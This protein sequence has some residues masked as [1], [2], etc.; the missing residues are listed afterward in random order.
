MPAI[1]DLREGDLYSNSMFSNTEA[2]I[3]TVVF[4]ALQVAHLSHSAADKMAP[5]PK[6]DEDEET[7]MVSSSEPRM[8][9][10]IGWLGLNFLTYCTA[11]QLWHGNVHLSSSTQYFHGYDE[12]SIAGKALEQ[13]TGVTHCEPNQCE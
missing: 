12:G 9:G 10:L 8:K 7:A 6:D 2:T 11:M 1:P 4:N 5:K 3:L 13:S